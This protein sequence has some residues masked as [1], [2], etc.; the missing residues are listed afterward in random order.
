MIAELIGIPNAIISYPIRFFVFFLALFQL[1]R[2]YSF[3]RIAPP[4]MRQGIA[5]FGLFWIVF[6]SRALYELYVKEVANSAN[7]SVYLTFPFLVSGIPTLALMQPMKESQTKFLRDFFTIVGFGC[8]SLFVLNIVKMSPEQKALRLLEGRFGLE[9]LNPISA[10]YVGAVAGLAA[11]S[12]IVEEGSLPHKNWSRIL[13]GAVSAVM[14]VAM[15]L[16]AASRAPLVAFFV[17]VMVLLVAE[18]RIQERA[19]PRRRIALSLGVSLALVS[20]ITL[21]GAQLIFGLNPFGRFETAFGDDPTHHNSGT[22]RLL[23]GEMAMEHFLTN[24]LIGNAAFI[25]SVEVYPHNILIEAL[26]AGGILAGIPLIF[27]AALAT[28][29]WIKM[30]TARQNPL[31]IALA[32]VWAIAA[33]NSGVIVENTESWGVMAVMIGFAVTLPFPKKSAEGSAL[34]NP[35]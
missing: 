6:Y 34:Q 30:I 10:G 35:A 32:F 20:V 8:T 25:N 26:M 11:I 18:Y 23:I 4:I 27:L 5:A 19:K 2:A 13:F 33:G 3:W 12:F 15:V 31:L 28:L 14:G 29:G 9:N 7:I 1:P 16:L 22:H 21:V 24:P 17:G